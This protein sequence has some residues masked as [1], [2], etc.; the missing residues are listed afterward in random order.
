M[1][2]QAEIDA[3]L[4][5]A[6]EIDQQDG[7]EGI[8]LADLM[9]SSGGERPQA[10]EG[11]DSSRKITA[12]NFWSPD[13]FSKEQMRAV[14]LVHEDLTERLTTSLPTFLRTNV[15]PRLVHTEQG[16]FH[17]FLKDFPPNSL[18][19]MIALAPL[20][21]QLVFTISPN[22]GFMILEQRLGGKMEGKFVD[23][24]LTD[25]D[26]SLLRG[27]VEHMIGD[28][29]AAWSKVVTV[30]PSLEDS[31]TNQHWVQMMIGNER[32]MLLTFELT[33][34]AVTG[35]MSIFLP[36]NTLKPIANELNPHIWI[37]GRKEH[38]QDPAARERVMHNLQ[39]VAMPVEVVLGSA[40]LKLSEILNLSVGDIIQLDNA[41]NAAL[42]VKVAHKPQFWGKV[43]RSNKHMAVQVSG[44]IRDSAP[45]E[46][47]L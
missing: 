18:F 35:T 27:L 11:G 41:V 17:D 13:R 42:V 28:I 21:G 40:D 26:Q 1:L 46:M 25:I 10:P 38:Q 44:V 43:G 29:K 37:A 5:G 16:R 14:E 9:N 30:E 6:I 2:S 24:P 36:F 31:T 19:H 8:N 47:D 23:R 34:Q 4:N 45:S 39:N 7:G 22:M 12:Y 3:L 15:R 32:V 33:I 20:P